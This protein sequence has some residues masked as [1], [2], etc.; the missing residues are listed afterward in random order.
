MACAQI[1]V[2]TCLARKQINA[3]CELSRG[4]HSGK[5][6]GALPTQRRSSPPQLGLGQMASTTSFDGRMEKRLP[7]A[8]VVQLAHA[9][10]QP[11]D[12]TELT[13]TDN[14]SAHG[15]RVVSYRP[16]Q[17]GELVQITSLKDTTT[18][19]GKVVYCRKLLDD[20]YCIGVQFQGQRV[21]WSAYKT[22]ST[23]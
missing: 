13:Y 14:V 20:R 21:T 11:H 10:S 2:F 1:Q 16:W 3:N 4:Y 7:I 19:P 17:A 23:T 18:L 12:G 8:I 15:A 5:C 9:Q 22:Y 6:S